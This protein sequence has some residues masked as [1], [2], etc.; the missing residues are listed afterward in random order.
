VLLKSTDHPKD[1]CV[2]FDGKMSQIT[3]SGKLKHGGQEPLT[4][5]TTTTDKMA[6]VLIDTTGST[7]SKVDKPEN[8]VDE[9]DEVFEDAHSE[10]E[11]VID[12]LAGGSDRITATGDSSESDKEKVKLDESEN[13]T[14]YSLK[15]ISKSLRYVLDNM[16]KL[17]A[18]NDSLCNKFDTTNTDLS[19]KFDDLHKD[20]SKEMTNNKASYDKKFDEL[21]KK[22]LGDQSTK[23]TELTEALIS[24]KLENTG[25]IKLVEDEVKINSSL[26]DRIQST[27]ETQEQKIEDLVNELAEL[28]TKTER[29]DEM[30]TKMADTDEYNDKRIRALQRGV[31]EARKLANDVEAHGRRWAIK[32]FGLPTPSKRETFSEVKEVFLTFLN[33]SLKITNVKHTDIDTAH[34]LGVPKN[35]KQVLLVRFFRREIYLLYPD[36]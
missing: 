21:E 35:G 6:D 13:D 26:L 31:D 19:K 4:T 1:K 15:Q 33:N 32:I 12:D 28:K 2:N 24:H 9:N 8:T 18:A 22:L 25:V 11:E 23:H 27:L 3:R 36:A 34:R 10:D 30:E 16:V 7:S 20:I 29:I 17:K 5:S 14:P